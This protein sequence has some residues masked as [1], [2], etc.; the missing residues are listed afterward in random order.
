MIWK[1]LETSVE[2]RN[3]IIWVASHSQSI[4]NVLNL[5]DFKTHCSL[6]VWRVR[7]RQDRVGLAELESQHEAI[8]RFNFI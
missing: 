8:F 5:T 3:G 6:E 2:T 4:D 7:R 1:P